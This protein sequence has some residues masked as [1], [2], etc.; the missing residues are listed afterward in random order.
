MSESMR[1]PGS[2]LS[3]MTTMLTKLRSV[4]APAPIAPPMKSIASLSSLADLRRRPLVEERGREVGEPGLV[5]RIERA[6][7]AHDHPHADD[8]LLVVQHRDDLQPVRQR[9]ELVGREVARRARPAAAAG[10]RTA[11]R[12]CAD[13]GAPERIDSAA[14][15]QDAGATSARAHRR[16]TS[17]AAPAPDGRSVSTSRFSG[18]K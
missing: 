15:R 1:R 4:P 6:A 2:K 14:T 13:R 3:F 11:T 8:R 16:A 9:L 5:L 18:V 12:V 17:R 10:L 7:G